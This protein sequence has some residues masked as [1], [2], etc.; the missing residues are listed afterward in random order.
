MSKNTPIHEFFNQQAQAT[1]PGWNHVAGVQLRHFDNLLQTARTILNGQGDCALDVIG[2]HKLQG[3]TLPV[4]RLAF[5]NAA[6]ITMRD[7]LVDYVA[8]VRSPDLAVPEKIV[9]ATSYSLSWDMDKESCK[10]LPDQAI[11]KSYAKNSR[12]FTFQSWDHE[13]FK[14][15]VVAFA[16][17]QRD[18]MA[19]AEAPSSP[20]AAV[21]PAAAL[22]LLP[23]GS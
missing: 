21:Q 2:E 11:R 16:K 6:S 18:A 14:Y 4:V 10:G 7:S 15:F 9:A 5:S 1:Q 3:F 8:T 17:L 22:A 13:S 12:H 19:R 20:V 23:A